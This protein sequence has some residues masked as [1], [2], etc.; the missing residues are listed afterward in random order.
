MH[1]LKGF[2]ISDGQESE[3]ET[4]FGFPIEKYSMIKPGSALILGL[5][6]KNSKEVILGLRREDEVLVLWEGVERQWLFLT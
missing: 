3:K 4:L 2:V 1:H 5:D 6:F